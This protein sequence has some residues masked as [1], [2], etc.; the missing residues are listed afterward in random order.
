MSRKKHRRL[1]SRF[2]VLRGGGFSG[3]Q[4]CGLNAGASGLESS[5]VRKQLG[6]I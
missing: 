3:F 5:E 6:Q 1:K 2:G 4:V